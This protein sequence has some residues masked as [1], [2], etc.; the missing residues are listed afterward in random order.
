MAHGPIHGMV[1]GI[2]DPKSSRT[3]EGVL[4][5]SLDAVFQDVRNDARSEESQ[6]VYT[7]LKATILRREKGWMSKVA[8]AEKASHQ[9]GDMQTKEGCSTLVGG[10][11]RSTTFRAGFEAGLQAAASN[12]VQNKTKPASSRTVTKPGSCGGTWQRSM[13]IAGPYQKKAIASNLNILAL[14]V[15][16][17]TKFT[18]GAKEQPSTSCCLSVL[19]QTQLKKKMIKRKGK[20]VWVKVPTIA[21][22]EYSLSDI[23][24]KFGCSYKAEKCAFCGRNDMLGE[25]SRFLRKAFRKGKQVAKKAKSV[26]KKLAAKAKAVAVKGVKKAKSGI[27]KLAT[28]TKAVAVKGVK[29]AK[30]GI[31]KLAKKA[32][33]G[34][35]PKMLGLASKILPRVLKFLIPY[36]ERFFAGKEEP[37]KICLDLLADRKLQTTFR[38]HFLNP[39]VS[40]KLVPL[41]YKDCACS[42]VA[43]LIEGQVYWEL[44]ED[45]PEWKQSFTKTT[46]E[47]I[48]L[49]RLRTTE[50]RDGPFGPLRMKIYKIPGGSIRSFSEI[51]QEVKNTALCEMH[52]SFDFVLCTNTKIPEEGGKAALDSNVRCCD[53]EL[54]ETPTKLSL[55]KGGKGCKLFFGLMDGVARTGISAIRAIYTS[56]AAAKCFKDDHKC[57]KELG[58]ATDQGRRGGGGTMSSQSDFSM[59]SGNR[60]GNSERLFLSE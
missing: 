33:A 21:G 10:A 13:I 47:G 52:V 56:M 43:P 30:S 55:V 14:L 54:V 16:Y 3:D 23:K 49:N 50:V 27:K 59:S 1:E 45:T 17:L 60:A 39:L 28:K 29:K 6:E 4:A 19:L 58:D 18:C 11:T 42:A 32:K 15:Y 51:S 46:K 57:G 5:Q 2:D 20:R 8:T 41:L 7:K 36:A 38:T 48:P 24:K 40:K 31:K 26:I 44:T 25:G 12:V 9:L 53:R 22:K 35:I 34:I 37:A